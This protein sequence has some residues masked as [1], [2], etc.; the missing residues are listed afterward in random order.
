MCTVK[1]IVKYDG[2]KYHGWQRQKNQSSVQGTIEK[3]LRNILNRDIN[4]DGSGRTDAGVHA[5]GQCFSFEEE[6]P[7][8][9]EQLRYVLNRSLPD[10]IFIISVQEESDA[11]H[12][13]YSAIAK[14]YE[15]HILLGKSRDPFRAPY[16]YYYPYP[17][18]LDAMKQAMTAFIGTHDFRTFMATGSN[19]EDTIRT[20]YQMTLSQRDELLI[21]TMTGDGFLYNMVRII[22]GTLLHVG[23][24]KIDS[25]LLSEIIMSKNRNRARFTAP[26]NG[27]YLQRV[28]YD[29]TELKNHL[30]NHQENHLGSSK[31]PV[32]YVNSYDNIL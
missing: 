8:T 26:A 15:Y 17:I 32:F 3:E 10:D 21:I 27:L 9:V 19:K 12:A 20:I 31:Q 22:I 29:K 30:E 2:S 7:M 18:D 14:T 16:C 28:F 4:I 13:R 25:Q 24:G 23:N 6:L 5:F 1:M 11:F